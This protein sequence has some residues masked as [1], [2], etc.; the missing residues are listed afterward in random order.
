MG[1]QT[2][3]WKEK[4]KWQPEQLETAPTSAASAGEKWATAAPKVVGLQLQEQLK[5]QQQEQQ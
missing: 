5:E 3:S 2:T 1:W 4:K